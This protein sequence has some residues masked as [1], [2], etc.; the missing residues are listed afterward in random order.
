MKTNQM[1][2]VGSTSDS[3]CSRP[4]KDISGM[5]VMLAQLS[6]EGR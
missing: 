3:A 1:S 4:P 6:G 2:S 5:P